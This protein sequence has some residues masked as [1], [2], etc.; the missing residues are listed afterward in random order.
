MVIAN[1]AAHDLLSKDEKEIVGRRC[2]EVFAGNPNPCEVCPVKEVFA[3]GVN[4]EREVEHEYLGKNMLVSCVPIYDKDVITG[5]I[6]TTR[7]ITEEKILKR[8][9]SKAQKMEAI[10]TLAGGIAHDFNNILG[11]I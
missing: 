5:Y 6:H 7:D 10:A 2:H 4:V 11:V 1:K 8:Q 3:R 9:L